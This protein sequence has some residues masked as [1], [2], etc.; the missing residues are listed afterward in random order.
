V[1]S[2]ISWRRFV[3][4]CALSTMAVHAQQV[5]FRDQV[6]PILEKAGC[7]A[8][9]NPEGVASPT[10][11]HFPEKDVPAARLDAFGMSLVEL[12]DRDSP[13]KSLLL[14]KP[15]ARV[16][17]A[18]GE[19]ITKSSPA[20]AA[21]RAWIDRLVKLSGKELAAALQYKQREAMGY[22]QAPTVA[23]RRLTH[24]QYNNTV[25][26]L[27]RDSTKPAKN[28][29]PEDYV[30]GFRN[31]YESLSISPILAEAYSRSAERL[32]S[33]VFRRGDSRGLIPCEPK[34]ADD[35][36]C[37]KKFIEQ[38]GRR[39]F[40]RSLDA[41]E[42][43]QY[44]ALF[45]NQ[46]SFLGGA[47]T[48]IE[49][50][51]QS[52]SFLFWMED[53]PDPKMR[54]YAVASQLSYFIWNTMPDEAL[55]ASAEN[56]GLNT[57]EGVE[58]AARRML[59]DPKAREGLDEFVSQWLRFDRVLNAARERRTYPLFNERL[60]ESMAEEARR[61]VGHIVWGDR[62]FREVFS[63]NYTFINS[64]LASV[65]GMDRPAGEWDRVEFS[66]A[67]ER[68]GI[69]GQAL[70]L[71][72]TS[73]P[74]DT[75]PTG[76]GLFVREQFLCQAVPDPPPG[77]DTNLPPLDEAKPQTNRGR[78]AMHA[79]APLCAGCHNLIDP[80][81]F[82]F[83]KFDAIGMRREQYKLVFGSDESPRGRMKEVLLDL[84]TT[85]WVTGIPNSEFKSPRG[86][87][88]LLAQTPQCNECV[89]KQLFRYMAGR[90]D[91]PADRPV[92]SRAL[93]RFRDSGFRFKE[94]IV[95]LITE[96]VTPPSAR[97]DVDGSH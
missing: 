44:E 64:D 84:D 28:F 39:A 85:A 70:F 59:A 42:I 83:E 52:P 49:A 81:G 91:M 88:E 36:A 50:M 19:R 9:H 23:L 18:G 53:T 27:L 65:Y 37:R 60:A 10:R 11:L 80:I 32:A 29:P 90:E 68:A 75:A 12:V 62:D 97:R 73:K 35:A 63:G 82:G 40:R 48:V 96:Q 71:T 87:G 89:V 20:E 8:C 33:N 76:R 66:P 79:N 31:Q 43:A 26:A 56:G 57:R 54:P 93:N 34:G 67:S 25:R 1:S 77:V 30:N 86:L 17:H 92:I 38:F 51:L 24:N 69:L 13:E 72:S 4:I 14:L 61:F 78:L 16:G 41:K 58:K 7:R 5:A 21:L 3:I 46:S 47:Q 15:T 2:R 6:Y 95:T 55:L 94:L 22:G 45:R 74:G